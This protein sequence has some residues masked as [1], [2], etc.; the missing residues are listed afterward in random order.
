ML[1][2]TAL[3]FASLAL[4]LGIAS[5]IPP[6]P[7]AAPHPS[8]AFA[9]S[10]VYAVQLLVAFV[11]L[12]SAQSISSSPSDI[13]ERL[14][15]T[16]P[17]SNTKRRFALLLPRVIAS[18]LALTW[19]LPSLCLITHYLDLPIYMPLVASVL[20]AISAFGLVYGLPG[21]GLPLRFVLIGIIGWIEYICVQ[22]MYTVPS[23]ASH[24]VYLLVLGAIVAGTF[25]LFAYSLITNDIPVERNSRSRYRFT[26]R[27]PTCFWMLKKS[28][29]SSGLRPGLITSFVLSTLVAFISWRMHIFDTHLLIGIAAILLAVCC[30]DIRSTP[31]V[32]NPTEITALRGTS[33]FVKHE[34][35]S[36]SL[37]F[38]AILPL[39]I[40]AFYM[41]RI[42]FVFILAAAMQL[43]LGMSAGIFAGTF[44]VPGPRDIAAQSMATLIATGVWF[45]PQLSL[46][47][48]F[49][50]TDVAVVQGLLA[51][52]LLCGSYAI[53]YKRNPFIWREKNSWL[54]KH[55]CSAFV[56]EV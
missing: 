34:I 8:L 12:G 53:E 26:T 38:I 29:R 33:Y 28:C 32:H 51:C 50:A 23:Q 10:I 3:A 30:S 54:K 52:L 16:L 7:S 15:I 36:C 49:S 47:V 40:I 22:R 56:V 14:L 19:V 55:P 43:A 1:R 21:L 37:G 42:D 13:T 39:L 24:F 17:L 31:A 46:F 25:L 44:I 4:G 11:L 6:L 45:L 35:F 9:C 27:L 18:I 20:G 5:Q 41:Q 48:Q 2:L